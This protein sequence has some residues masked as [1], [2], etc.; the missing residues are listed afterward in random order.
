MKRRFSMTRPCSICGLSV[1]IP[2][3]QGALGRVCLFYGIRIA[4]DEINDP[5]AP[6][7]RHCVNDGN[8]FTWP[9]RGISALELLDWRKDYLDWHIRRKSLRVAIVAGVV[10]AIVGLVGLFVAA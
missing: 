7:R 5:S 6:L 8:H 10:S 9:A 3:R 4:P 2:L 1:P